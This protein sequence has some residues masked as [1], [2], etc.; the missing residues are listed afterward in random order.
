MYHTIYTCTYVVLHTNLVNFSCVLTYVPGLIE[1][2]LLRIGIALF[3]GWC[4][5]VRCERSAYYMTGK[6]GLPFRNTYSLTQ[7]ILYA[8]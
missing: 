4:Q 6:A 8:L 1:S 3:R 7:F 5:C 2:F